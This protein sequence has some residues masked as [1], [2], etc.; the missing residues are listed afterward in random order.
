[1]S[2]AAGVVWTLPPAWKTRG[3]RSQG[4]RQ[5]RVFHP[6]LDGTERRPQ[7]PHQSK[8]LLTLI[9]IHPFFGGQ[10]SMSPGGQF[11]VSLD[12]TESTS[13]ND[14]PKAWSSSAAE[15][16]CGLR[17]PATTTLVSST[18]RITCDM[19]SLSGS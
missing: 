1:M 2:T 14:R 9:Y 11:R 5:E 19:V 10:F 13:V 8:L 7:P 3:H 12:T 6:G 18:S 16:P 17:R 15:A 4:L